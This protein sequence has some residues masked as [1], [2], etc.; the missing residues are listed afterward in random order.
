MPTSDGQP[1]PAPVVTPDG[2]PVPVLKE[3][4]PPL[5]PQPPEGTVR[6]KIAIMGTTPSR[7]LGPIDDPEWDIWT[8]GPGGKDTHS[9]DRLFEVH[10]I[11]PEN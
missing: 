3:E 9:W 6:R 8:I 5:R 7:M 11:W 1:H 4:K 10:H 2:G